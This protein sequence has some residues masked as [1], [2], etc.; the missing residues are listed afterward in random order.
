MCLFFDEGDIPGTF[1]NVYLIV[2]DIGHEAGTEADPDFFNSLVFLK[3]FYSVFDTANKRIGLA[4][5]PFTT[6]TTN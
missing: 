4:T 3:R 6:T 1:K 2:G 5:T